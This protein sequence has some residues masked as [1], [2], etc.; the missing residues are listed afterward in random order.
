MKIRKMHSVYSMQFPILHAKL[1]IIGLWLAF[2]IENKFSSI[3]IIKS[4]IELIGVRKFLINFAVPLD[5]IFLLYSILILKGV[6]DESS[7]M[8]YLVYVGNIL[9]ALILYYV[10]NLFCNQDMSI[11]LKHSTY[12]DILLWLGKN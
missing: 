4:W 6:R 7:I 11:C 12:Y 10:T 3:S 9:Q 1:V 8:M 2:Y 5:G